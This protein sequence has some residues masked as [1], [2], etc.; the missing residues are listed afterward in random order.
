MRR[1]RLTDFLQCGC[2]APWP[3]E[4]LLETRAAG[5]PIALPAAPREERRRRRRRGGEAGNDATT[6]WTPSLAAI[7]E[8]CSAAA[9]DGRAA[10]AKGGVSPRVLPRANSDDHR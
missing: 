4:A 9:R 10:K 7:S 6:T 8:N 5:P 3:E 1:M 2:G